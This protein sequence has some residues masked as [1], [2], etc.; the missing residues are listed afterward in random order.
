MT[1]KLNAPHKLLYVLYLVFLVSVVGAFRAV[2]SIAIGL[3]IVVSFIQ[4]KKLTGAWF[5]RNLRNPFFLTCSLFFLLQLISLAYTGNF[6]E[7][8]KHVQV[9]SALLFIPL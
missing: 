7:G 6:Q 2:S 9:K 5:N 8:W 3:I 1:E 4:N